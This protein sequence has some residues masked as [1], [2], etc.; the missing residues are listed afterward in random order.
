VQAVALLTC[1]ALFNIA[2]IPSGKDACVAEGAVPALVAALRAH[3]SVP[4]VARTA[5]EALLKLTGASPPAVQACLAAGLGRRMYS[6]Q[7]KLPI[8]LFLGQPAGCSAT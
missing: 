1:G 8:P 6:K 4:A 2:S 7:Q 3:V 5:C